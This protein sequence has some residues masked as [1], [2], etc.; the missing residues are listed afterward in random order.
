[1]Y[2]VLL[3]VFRAPLQRPKCFNDLRFLPVFIGSFH[4]M[5]NIFYTFRRRR[6][7][8]ITTLLEIINS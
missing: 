1:V 5:K 3:C 8:Y 7:R 2:F 6:F 4:E